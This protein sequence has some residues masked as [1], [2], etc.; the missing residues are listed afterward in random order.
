[1]P[2]YLI[3]KE[4]RPDDHQPLER[5]TIGQFNG[6]FDSFLI[7][8]E[9]IIPTKLHRSL[10]LKESETIPLVV[11]QPLV[12]VPVVR[13]IGRALDHLY[14]AE[15]TQCSKEQ[16]HYWDVSQELLTEAKN[17]LAGF[18]NKGFPGEPVIRM[19][20]ALTNFMYY[21]RDRVTNLNQGV[22]AVKC[23]GNAVLLAREWLLKPYLV[24]NIPLQ[25]QHLSSKFK[26]AMRL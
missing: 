24:T 3:I 12:F 4:N 23:I 1:M 6:D 7:I 9:L 21:R 17:D 18:Q 15:R 8:L 19:E 20:N 10:R 2:S 13:K 26:P 22:D 5:G 25:S 11:G 14:H 16:Q